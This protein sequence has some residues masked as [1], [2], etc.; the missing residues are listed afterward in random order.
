MYLHPPLPSPVKII[1]SSAIKLFSCAHF[2]ELPWDIPLPPPLRPIAWPAY[3]PRTANRD[4]TIEP[5]F[6]HFR[7]CL[8]SHSVDSLV[9]NGRCGVAD[10]ME[11]SQ[12]GYTFALLQREPIL[13]NVKGTL[14]R[15]LG[16]A[17]YEIP[18]Q[19]AEM[20]GKRPSFYCGCLEGLSYAGFFCGEPRAEFSRKLN[21]V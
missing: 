9:L 6:P 7:R 8:H 20:K 19:I 1:R 17:L 2:V 11:S 4:R 10:F 3:V 16:I 12:C 15:I 18:P 14:V 21:S 13:H 5:S